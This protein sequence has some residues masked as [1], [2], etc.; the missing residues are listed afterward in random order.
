MTALLSGGGFLFDGQ[1]AVCGTMS[2][3][4]LAESPEL[5]AK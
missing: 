1:I 5:E 4:H 3:Y 2:Y